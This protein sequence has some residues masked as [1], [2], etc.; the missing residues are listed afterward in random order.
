MLHRAGSRA[1]F[2]E[3]TQSGQDHHAIGAERP[4]GE[5]GGRCLQM[6]C[7]PSGPVTATSALTSSRPSRANR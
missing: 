2:N 3:R 4:N 5:S 7:A 1:A 6:T